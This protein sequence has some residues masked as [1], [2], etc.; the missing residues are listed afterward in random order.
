VSAEKAAPAAAGP[1]ARNLIVRVAS[2]AVLV[3]LAIAAAYAGGWYW[4]ALVT[5]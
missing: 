2:A 1:A 3:P 4:T 5:L